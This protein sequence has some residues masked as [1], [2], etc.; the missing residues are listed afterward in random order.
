MRNLILTGAIA[1]SAALATSALA[2]PMTAVDLATLKRISAPTASP[3]GRWVVFQLT[4]TAPDSY[5]RTTGLWLVDRRAKDASPVRVADVAGKNESSPSF[6]MGGTLFFIAD[7]SGSDQIWSINTRSMNRPPFRSPMKRPM[8]QALNC[9]L[10]GAKFSLGATS[11]VNA[12]V[13]AVT[14]RTRALRR[15]R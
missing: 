9:H 8:L 11:P 1:L 3:D 6:G 5:D 13:S 14:P 7:A 10:M 4:E 2:R 15:S 12:Q